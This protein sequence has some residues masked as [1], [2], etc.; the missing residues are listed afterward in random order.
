M[1]ECGQEW[2]F[3]E[4]GVQQK[5]HVGGWLLCDMAAARDSF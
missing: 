5:M 3:V 4:S 1:V 2:P